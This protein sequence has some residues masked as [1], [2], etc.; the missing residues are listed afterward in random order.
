M[1]TVSNSVYKID[2]ENYLTEDKIAELK[3]LITRNV[4]TLTVGEIYFSLKGA[5]LRTVNTLIKNV[6]G[7]TRSRYLEFT[8]IDLYLLLK[9]K[10]LSILEM[11]KYEGTT[12]Q[13]IKKRIDRFKNKMEDYLAFKKFEKQQLESIRN[14]NRNNNKLVPINFYKPII[15]TAMFFVGKDKNQ[16]RRHYFVPEL[17]SW[18]PSGNILKSRLSNNGIDYLS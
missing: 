13:V 12:G 4:N 6:I 1:K 16:R 5:S 9:E 18:F 3:E 15:M 8:K 2:I 17:N 10:G 7:T 11:A 14:K